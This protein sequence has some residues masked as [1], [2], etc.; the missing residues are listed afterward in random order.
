MGET[1]IRITKTNDRKLVMIIRPII[2]PFCWMYKT[3]SIW[4]D[5][6]YYIPGNH[7]ITFYTALHFIL[8][9]FA[10]GFLSIRRK[11]RKPRHIHHAFIM[12]ALLIPSVHIT[13][14]VFSSYAILIREVY[15]QRPQ[16]RGSDDSSSNGYFNYV[17]LPTI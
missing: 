2:K 3:F 10:N 4:D 5:F 8:H 17:A 9:C 7:R 14:E 16:D 1:T 11:E 6:N 15:L 13:T 12:A